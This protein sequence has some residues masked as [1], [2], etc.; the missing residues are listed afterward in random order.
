MAAHAHG[1][2]HAARRYQSGGG[3]GV[4]EALGLNRA[5]SS[6][7]AKTIRIM[8]IRFWLRGV[9]N[10]ADGDATQYK[11]KFFGSNQIVEHKAREIVI[12]GGM[13]VGELGMSV[14]MNLDGDAGFEN[15]FKVAGY[16]GDVAMQMKLD[17]KSLKVCDWMSSPSFL[18][19]RALH[20]RQLASY[21]QLVSGT[22]T[23]VSI[24][25]ERLASF[26]HRPEQDGS[27]NVTPNGN[28]LT[29]LGRALG[30]PGIAPTQL[31]LF[32]L[33]F[34]EDIRAT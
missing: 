21:T 16:N 29:M 3:G 15:A 26:C 32:A 27:I 2:E 34:P 8:P 4:L 10:T 1:R 5:P 20:W 19:A 30:D 9:F 13:T 7:G 18:F 17:L 23:L 12:H 33:N 31:G 28:M 6:A 14:K 24:G 25:S 11:G 22:Q